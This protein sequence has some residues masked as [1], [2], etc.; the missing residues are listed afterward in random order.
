MD[1]SANKA[2][3]RLKIICW[4]CAVVMM[5]LCVYP[6]SNRH[7]NGEG[8]VAI[9]FIYL[10]G[11]MFG[12]LVTFPYW[13]HANYYCKQC[14]KIIY[15]T[16]SDTPS[17]GAFLRCENGH[18]AVALTPG[19]IMGI[20][21]VGCSW[22]FLRSAT[23]IAILYPMLG[24]LAFYSIP[25]LGVL[26]VLFAIYSRKRLHLARIDGYSVN[27]AA[28][29]GLGLG[30]VIGWISGIALGIIYHGFPMY[31]YDLHPLL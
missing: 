1:K 8:P 17:H 16:P 15:G 2:A 19:W 30:C 14:N 22:S 7:P 31:Q 21:G 10:F 28:N 12:I 24:K 6:A 13:L 26:V 3:R 4:V 23:L 27:W 11:I 29:M 5:S 20:F 9:L 25:I 18:S